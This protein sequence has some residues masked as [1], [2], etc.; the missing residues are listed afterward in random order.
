MFLFIIS[1]KDSIACNFLWHWDCVLAIVLLFWLTFCQ[2]PFT[3]LQGWLMLLVIWVHFYYFKAKLCIYWCRNTERL[4]DASFLTLQQIK[5]SNNL[6]LY[7]RWIIFLSKL[8]NV[9]LKSN[10]SVCGCETIKQ[11]QFHHNEQDCLPIST[12]FV[13]L[14][15]LIKLSRAAYSTGRW[16]QQILSTTATVVCHHIIKYTTTANLYKR[17]ILKWRKQDEINLQLK[18]SS[19]KKW[20]SKIVKQS[21]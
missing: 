5:S 9:Q 11:L 19:L 13:I 7:Q 20:K 14:F 18:C 4:I 3:L 12:T 10:Y 17:K 16:F 8:F 15:R 6:S 1:L 2:I 21:I